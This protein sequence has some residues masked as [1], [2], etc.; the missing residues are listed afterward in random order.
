MDFE[1]EDEA[2]D[3][4]NNLDEDYKYCPLKRGP[5]NRHCVAYKKGV[6]D[7]IR[8]VDVGTVYTASM[9]TCVIFKMEVI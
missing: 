4:L 3:Y 1:T 8:I 7:T 9:P 2:L 5:C 6:V